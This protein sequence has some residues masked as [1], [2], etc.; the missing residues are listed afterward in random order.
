MRDLNTV[1]SKRVMHRTADVRRRSPSH[2]P[3]TPSPMGVTAPTP[4]TT[5]RLP[6]FISPLHDGSHRSP[7]LCHR[8]PRCPPS[9]LTTLSPLAVVSARPLAVVSARP[10]AVVPAR[11]LARSPA[12]PL[13]RLPARPLARSPRAVP[14][15]HRP[16]DPR[17][18]PR[19]DPVD[20]HRPD[21]PLGGRAADQ[22]P[23]GP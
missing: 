22:R 9:P 2:S 8:S 23:A 21:H 19:R 16:P 12:C 5:T 6:L 3:S 1:G 10:L 14:P 17:Q 18:R 11:P 7:C 4:V 13:A 20:E 15:L